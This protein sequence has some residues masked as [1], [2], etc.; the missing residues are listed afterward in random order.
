MKTAPRDTIRRIVAAVSLPARDR[1]VLAVA[2]G[3]TSV[4][5]AGPG[6]PVAGLAAALYGHFYCVPRSSEAPASADP[7]AFLA[8]LR[9]ANPLAPRFEPGWT[10]ARIDRSGILL[11]DA[12]GRQRLA[13]LS[14][15]A[16]YGSMAPGQPVRLASPREMITGAAGHYLILGRPIREPR[17]GSQVRFYWNIGPGGAATFLSAAG[18][19]LD[20][21][22][23]PFQAKVPVSPQG[24]G[25]AD[26]GV[27]YLD[28]EHVE[29]ASDVIAS[30]RRALGASMRPETPL[31]AR[32]L[33]PGLAFAESPPSG[34][35]FGM[36]RCRLVAEGLVMAF[37][38]GATGAKA[39]VDAVCERLTG[40]GFDLA[41]LERNPATHYPYRFEALAA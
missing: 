27:L 35:S 38:R 33:A 16:P 11:A 36:H 25:R 29:A 2:G 26:C 5:V 28:A 6:G 13:A 18:A 1:A 31:F 30:T 8:T 40:Y 12:M 22:R 23:I 24:Y 19:G 3:E 15:I 20:R 37:E 34:D 7:A 39:R 32:P 17:A 4:P 21:R 10:V 9:A 41:A 14:D